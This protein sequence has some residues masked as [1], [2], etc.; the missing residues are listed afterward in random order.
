MLTSS[1]STPTQRLI[2]L[3]KVQR[4]FEEADFTATYKFALLM[5]LADLAVE[6]GEDGDNDLVLPMCRIAE[7]FIQYYLPQSAPYASG[8]PGTYPKVLSQNLGAQAAVVKRLSALR[9]AGVRTMRDA[10]GHVD[11]QKHVGEVAKIVRSMPVKFLQNIGS[12]MDP[13]LYD[14]PKGRSP[15][16][17]QVDVVDNLRYFHGIIHRLA[18]AAWLE[19]IRNNR[20]NLDAIGQSDDLEG[21]LFGSP[22]RDLSKVADILADYQAGKC[23][24]CGRSL[25]S[26]GDVD[27]FVAWSRYPR[28]LAHN[29]VLAHASCNRR[30]SDLLAARE[31]LEHWLERN[32]AIGDSILRDIGALGFPA[33]LQTME[34]V[35]RWAYEQGV[36][37]SAHGWI[38]EKRFEV[39]GKHYLDCFH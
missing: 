4:L 33:S 2:F 10:V 23:F 9:D 26:R 31:H 7:K 20:R 22:R 37:V 25:R 6:D 34:K 11:W 12:E 16:V 24:Y 38:A 30:K 15:L 39:V 14:L 35:A 3:Q 21:F 27:H 18:K 28:D 13:F 8:R 36:A 5:A 32:A 1:K 17:L 29:F 19:H